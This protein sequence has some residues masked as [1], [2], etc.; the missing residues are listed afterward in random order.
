[1][2]LHHITLH[3]VKAGFKEIKRKRI[4]RM[5]LL[6]I[7]KVTQDSRTGKRKKRKGKNKITKYYIVS[8]IQD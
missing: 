3:V 1:M 2:R 4:A 7:V 5:K 6:Y 8:V